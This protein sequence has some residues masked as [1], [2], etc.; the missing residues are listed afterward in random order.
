[1]NLATG[2]INVPLEYFDIAIDEMLAQIGGVTGIDRGYVFLHDLSNMKTSNTHEW[3]ADGVSREIDNL[4]N[5][6][7]RLFEDFLAVHHQGEIIQVLDLEQLPVKH[8]M[9]EISEAQ[10]VRSLLLIPL[11]HEQSAIGFVGFDAVDDLKRFSDREISLLKFLSEII[12]HAL[13]GRQAEKALQDSES[14]FRSFV[15]NSQ[16][17]IYMLN[18]DG[19]FTYVSP[20]W[21]LLLGHDVSEVEGKPFTDFLFAA[22]VERCLEMDTRMK[23]FSTVLYIGTALRGGMLRTVH[24]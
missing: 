22:D 16:D 20:S 11:L 2:F 18:G 24:C 14:K 19:A 13:A 1:L 12:S 7:L 3:C 9:R 6:D 4:Q 5:V 21:K 15:E 8:P 23:A 10:G 17:I